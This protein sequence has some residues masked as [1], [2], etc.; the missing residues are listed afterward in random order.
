MHA[1]QRQIIEKAIVAISSLGGK[2]HIEVDGETFGAPIQKVIHRTKLV[3]YKEFG[4][5]QKIQDMNV[6]DVL[7][8]LKEDILKA[9]YEITGMGSNISAVGCRTFGAGTFTTMTNTVTGNIECM[10]TA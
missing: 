9:G 1:I 7:V 8:F 10:R 3:S 6:G 5:I 2:Y 4:H